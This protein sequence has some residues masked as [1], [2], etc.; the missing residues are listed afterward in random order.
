ML[1]LQI[2]ATATCPTGQTAAPS[3]ISSFP[4]VSTKDVVVTIG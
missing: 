4:C 2:L 3:N 1:S